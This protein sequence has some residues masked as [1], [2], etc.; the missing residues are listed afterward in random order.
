[1]V[2]HINCPI[3]FP[4]TPWQYYYL[5]FTDEETEAQRWQI[6]WSKWQCQRLRSCSLTPNSVFFLYLSDFMAYQYDSIGKKITMACW[7][8]LHNSNPLLIGWIVWSKHFTLLTHLM[9]LTLWCRPCYYPHFKARGIKW[10]V[11]WFVSGTAGIQT[12][13]ACLFSSLSSHDIVLY[14]ETTFSPGERKAIS[15]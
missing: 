10:L 6:I 8:S 7:K 4:V 5:I 15:E 12:Q 14:L 11:H 3:I 13:A 9:L 1:M 2:L